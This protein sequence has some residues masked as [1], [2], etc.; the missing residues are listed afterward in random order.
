MLGIYSSMPLSITRVSA[1]CARSLLD[2][3]ALYSVQEEVHLFC[4]VCT[5]LHTPYSV[6]TITLRQ[7]TM[8]Y[9]AC[10]WYATRVIP[11][12]KTPPLCL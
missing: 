6:A 1:V 7:Q 3:S 5:V 8:K 4:T 9:Y 2:S 12:P 11:D 10:M